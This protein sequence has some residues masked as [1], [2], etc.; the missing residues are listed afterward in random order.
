MDLCDYGCGKEA[1]YFFKNGKKCCNRWTQKCDKVREFTSDSH[2]GL[3]HTEKTKKRLKEW[4][5]ERFSVKENCTFYGKQHTKESKIKIGKSS[6]G[7]IPS[8]ETRKKMSLVRCGNKNANWKG[9]VSLEPYCFEF[10]QDL[11]EFIKERDSFICKN[12]NCSNGKHLCVHHIDYNK[13]NCILENLITLCFSCNSK[14]NFKRDFW[15]DFY[16]KI[17]KEGT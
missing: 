13:K 5:K 7:R 3:G 10:T 6:A 8:K 17:L 16:T 1:K 12:P 15:K 4:A 14:A 11:K 9:G 2:I